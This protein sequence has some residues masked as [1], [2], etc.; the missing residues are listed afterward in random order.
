L[1][2]MGA[3]LARL[4]T[5]L[6]AVDFAMDFKDFWYIVA[7]S[8]D[9]QGDRVVAA[10][11]FDQWLALFRDERGRAVAL[12]DRCLH[13]CAQLSKGVVKQGQLQCA[14]HGWVYNGEGRV[15]DIPS[16]SRRQ[17][18]GDSA[19]RRARSFQL[20]ESDGYVYARLADAPPAEPLQPFRIPFYGAKGWAAIRLKNLFRNNVTNCVENFVDIPHTAFVHPKIFRVRRNETL[21]ATVRRKEG[22]VQV[23]YSGERAN[24]GIFAWFL[25]PKGQEIEHSD[26]FFMPNVTSVDYRF[27]D[28]RRFIITSQSIPVNEEETL[29]YTDLTY[30]YGI[31]NRLARPL[32]RRQAQTI[33]DQDIEILGNQLQTIKKFGRRFSNTEADVI[34]IF[35]ES[36]RDALARGEDPRRL[37]EKHQQIEFRV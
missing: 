32:I 21:T 28:H 2:P 27:S 20:C 29:V 18:Q 16:A 34:H 8:Q 22:R 35:I 4:S 30:H 36:I 14:Y 33:I 1:A 26:T 3:A 15:I 6:P 13:R 12:E 23:D 24:L 25:N 10:R 5:Q 9:L 37:P 17:P 31:W 19:Q 7:E 11:L